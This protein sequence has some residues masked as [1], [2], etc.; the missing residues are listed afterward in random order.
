MLGNNPEKQLSDNLPAQEGAGTSNIPN[1]S[2]SGTNDLV[3]VPN[4]KKE[5]LI[6]ILDQARKIDL[7]SERVKEELI[8]LEDTLLTLVVDIDE[9][10]IYQ[11]LEAALDGAFSGEWRTHA[12]EQLKTL[13]LML[14]KNRSCTNN[15]EVEILFHGYRAPLALFLEKG[16][17]PPKQIEDATFKFYRIGGLNTVSL[18]KHPSDAISWARGVPILLRPTNTALAI[19]INSLERKKLSFNDEQ[20]HF[21][22][23]G[24]I[25]ANTFLAVIHKTP[26]DEDTPRYAYEAAKIV[27]A[28]LTFNDPHLVLPCMLT[29]SL[30]IKPTYKQ[31]KSGISNDFKDCQNI[32]ASCWPK[33]SIREWKEILVT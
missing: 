18:E 16:I 10:E 30:G 20:E 9:N 25:P 23:E 7:K 14:D 29:D 21:L 27:V 32:M 26:L 1:S 24:D 3:N 17:V 2:E 33:L 12:K 8:K 19:N 31:L 22:Y 15:G 13:L 6:A 4:Q 11:I 28:A 5:K